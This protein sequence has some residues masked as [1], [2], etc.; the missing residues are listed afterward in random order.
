MCI[1]HTFVTL[2]STTY[3]RINRRLQIPL[4]QCGHMASELQSENS[5][6][7]GAKSRGPLTADSKFRSSRNATTH[8]MLSKTIIIEGEVGARFAALLASL[9]DILKPRNSLEDGLIEDLATCRWRQR[10][11][12]SMETAAYS[13]EIRRQDPQTAAECPA[14]RAALALANNFANSRAIALLSRAPNPRNPAKTRSKPYE[15][16]HSRDI[17]QQPCRTGSA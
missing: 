15:N 7:N 1:I 5:R 9:Q 3:P 8:G 12:L 13:H 16:T 4:P 10:R 14:T 6:R 2:K 11:L 17:F